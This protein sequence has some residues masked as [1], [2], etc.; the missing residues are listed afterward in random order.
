MIDLEQVNQALNQYLR[1]GTFPVA[2]RMCQSAAEIPDG[3]Q[4]PKR[5]LGFPVT[6]CQGLSIARRYG[7][8][9]AIGKDDQCCP[10]GAVAMGFLPPK[11]GFLNGTY[12]ELASLGRKETSA[13]TQQALSRLEYGKYSY[14][15]AA[16][17]Q[18]AAYEPHLIVVYGNPAQ[19]ARLIQSALY[20]TGG[21]LSWSAS[22]RMGCSTTIARTIVNDECQVVVAG[23]GERR[24]A[25]TQD[26][27]LAFTIPL[28][29]VS[30]T[31]KGLEATHKQL[32]SMRYPT[33]SYLQEWKLPP[34]YR[35]LTEL[36][37]QDEQA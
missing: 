35:K 8:T 19:I 32:S 1:L 9:M 24:I 16:P 23:G 31:T 27:E 5:D 15:L 10:Y 26:H 22:G 18:N 36:L 11:E 25:L 17:L 7:W 14:L 28:S 13:R 20:Q 30:L 33:W 29:K 34:G 21:A 2:V 12:E 37:M 3:A 4:F 6:V